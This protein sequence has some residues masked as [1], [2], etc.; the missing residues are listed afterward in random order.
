VAHSSRLCLPSLKEVQC[1]SRNGAVYRQCMAA[2]I[3]STVIGECLRL[4]GAL[5]S[6]TP[7]AKASL[8][9]RCGGRFA[10]KQTISCVSPTSTLISRRCEECVCVEIKETPLAHAIDSFT[11][12]F[13]VSR[14]LQSLLLFSCS[15]LL[16]RCTIPSSPWFQTCANMSC[17]PLRLPLCP[18]QPSAFSQ[19]C[20]PSPEAGL[21]LET[22]AAHCVHQGTI[23]TC[24][25]RST[26]RTSGSWFA[27]SRTRRAGVVVVVSR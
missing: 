25:S 4:S 3:T 16:P 13:L 10:K 9:V 19:G 12:M 26:L 27:A 8:Q 7:L 5:L 6:H 21:F 2:T 22:G 14:E 18:D 24:T 15:L 1:I 23:K 17:F 20:A 11:R